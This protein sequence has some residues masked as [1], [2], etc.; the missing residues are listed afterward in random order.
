MTLFAVLAGMLFYLQIV[1]GHHYEALSRDN[2]I[3][4][5]PLKAPRG[6]IVDRNGVLVA[7]SRQSFSVCVIPRL[8]IHNT[9]EIALLSK[10]LGVSRE[11]IE[12]KLSSC[13]SSYRPTVIKRDV[14]FE[15]ISIIEE[16]FADLPDVMVIS[17]PVRS[18]PLGKEFCHLVGYVGEVNRREIE[19]SRRR[20]SAGDLI[21]KSGIER[22]YERF[23][24]GTDG[25][26][27]VRI[28][29]LGSEAAVDLEDLP[30]K[31]PRQGMRLVLA[32]EASLQ[33][34]ASHLLEGN[35]GCICVI[36]VRTG[37]ILAL[38]SS[39]G[40]DPSLF[41]VG[42]SP[43]DWLRIVHDEQKP[44]LNRAV[45]SAYPPGSTF[46]IVTAAVALEEGILD[47]TTTFAPCRG[48]Y[49][50]G[51]RTFLCWKPE[52]HGRT[53][54]TRALAVSCDVYFYQVGERMHLDTFMKTA[55]KWLLDSTTGIDLPDEAKG[56]LP[57]SSYYLSLIHI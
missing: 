50:F 36:D 35:R 22:Q 46:K 7:G 13:R 57:D 38:V 20:Y 2:Y 1:R 5:V 34:V 45:Q 26:K 29:R 24:A 32:A 41:A 54:L 55:K 23:L 4:E 18:Y 3:V 43:E 12:E 21:G 8:I 53:N 42:I 19:E 27:F 6:D 25:V 37:E 48:S 39:P 47:V 49:R 14:S 11:V 15:T 44:L 33:T 28:D 40:F 51:R 9:T 31:A 52:G 56:L 17:E 10:V 16:M 30:S